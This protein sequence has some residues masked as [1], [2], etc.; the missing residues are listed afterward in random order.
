[1]FSCVFCLKRK[2]FNS[3]H[4]ITI[5]NLPAKIGGLPVVSLE[6][7]AFCETESLVFVTLPKSI[8]R[9]GNRAFLGC[10]NLKEITIPGS[11]KEI[12]FICQSCDNLRSVKI[13][14]SVTTIGDYA[15][16]SC[17]NLRSIEIPNSVTKIGEYAFGYCDSLRRAT[18]LNC[19]G[20]KTS[21]F[22]SMM[23][24]TSILI[25]EL[26]DTFVAAK[27]LISNYVGRYWE[28]F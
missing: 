3:Y 6:D 4:T 12:G 13:P 7:N 26:S 19:Q 24:P 14:N 20:W 2:N 15:F 18:F 10:T 11:V 5:L 23:L 25:S 28:I 16:S 8:T 1:M 9:I 21:F 17:V 27:L 22:E